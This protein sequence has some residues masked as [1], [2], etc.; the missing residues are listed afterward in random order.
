MADAKMVHSFAKRYQY[1]WILIADD[2]NYIAREQFSK[3]FEEE[4]LQSKNKSLGNL[5]S[6]SNR[7]K[8]AYDRIKVFTQEG[9]N[10]KV[11]CDFNSFDSSVKDQVRTIEA[12]PRVLEAHF[13]ED[14][15]NGYP[16]ISKVTH[17]LKNEAHIIKFIQQ[18]IK[19]EI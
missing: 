16:A 17:K 13:E 14:T 5:I 19:E 15:I 3:L 1:V 10:V 4:Q 12:D 18:N 9:V 7:Q 8:Q 6:G 2:K 11:L